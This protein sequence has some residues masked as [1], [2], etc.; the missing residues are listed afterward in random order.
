MLL[1]HLLLQCALKT[2]NQPFKYP[3]E[4]PCYV[5]P[6]SGFRVAQQT[7]VV[8]PIHISNWILLVSILILV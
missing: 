5:P 7:N 6:F 1:S 8:W 4:A 3:E 2:S